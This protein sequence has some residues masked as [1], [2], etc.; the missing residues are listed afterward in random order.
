MREPIIIAA[1]S[2]PTIRPT[3]DF[4]AGGL[5]NNGA[6]YGREIPETLIRF[7]YP[8]SDLNSV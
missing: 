3:F 8:G 5:S 6:S 1:K 2:P 7:L 4:W